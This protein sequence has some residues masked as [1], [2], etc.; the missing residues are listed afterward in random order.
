MAVFTSRLAVYMQSLILGQI[1][2]DAGSI[3][4]SKFNFCQIQTAD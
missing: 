2:I 3:V 1:I 4:I